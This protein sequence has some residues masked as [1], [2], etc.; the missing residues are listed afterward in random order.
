MNNNNNVKEVTR[1]NL[2]LTS[3][4][5]KTRDGKK[6]MYFAS[7]KRSKELLPEVKEE[8]CRGILYVLRRYGFDLYTSKEKLNL[9]VTV[10]EIG[11]KEYHLI[12][13]SKSFGLLF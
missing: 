5:I 8:I 4:V 11:S 3:L 10:E 9:G 2:N 12:L 7:Q 13:P 1:E 6:L